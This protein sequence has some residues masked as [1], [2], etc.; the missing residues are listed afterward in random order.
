MNPINDIVCNLLETPFSRWTDEDKR[1]VLL[2]G[3]PT[4]ILNID[5]KKELKK[6][7]RSYKINF[8][9]S[10]FSEY[11]WLCSSAALQKLFCWSCLLFSNKHCVWNRDGFTDFLNIT[12][13]LRK[14]G[15]SGEHLKCQLMLR[16][17][18]QNQNTIAD[19]LKENARLY[20]LNF[21]EKVRLNRLCL[22]VVIR[23]VLYLVGTYGAKSL[24]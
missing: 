17:F 18:E 5:F 21:N 13:S 2:H 12:R 7:G 15:D 24:L 8:K 20:K 11:N 10:W 4:G 3:R 1:D 9:C 19:A 6:S 22:R 14:H 16:N 23:A